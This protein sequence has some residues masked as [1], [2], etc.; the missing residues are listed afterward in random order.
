[1][2]LSVYGFGDAW[3]DGNYQ[4]EELE[5][6]ADHGDGIYF[7]IDSPEEARRAFLSTVS[8]SL[9]TVA[10]DVKIQVEFNPA[11]VKGYRL[12]GYENRVLANDDFD[13]DNVDGGELGA[14]LSMT[15]LYEIIP[16]GSSE[17]V[18]EDLLGTAPVLEPSDDDDG[19]VTGEPEVAE[20]KSAPIGAGDVVQVRVRYKGTR[21]TSSEL[22]SQSYSPDI[23]NAEPSP[24]LS[25][26]AAVSEL[27]MQLRGSQYREP[28]SAGVL[29][30]L[31][32]RAEPLDAEGAVAEFLSLLDKTGAL[33][34]P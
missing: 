32:A 11:Q 7:Y 24:K 5:Q 1:V 33:P 15:A 34:A 18:P 27:A 17:A 22:I 13:N 12:I 26:A 3:D 4:D 9:L 6:L 14:G 10:K 23:E 19:D 2:F 21:A 16:A 31:A 8:G 20:P 29:R 28:R 25:F 30:Q